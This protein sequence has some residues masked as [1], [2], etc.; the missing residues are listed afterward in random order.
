MYNI[1]LQN[2]KQTEIFYKIYALYNQEQGGR[3]RRF[4]GN[5]R[6]MARIW[7]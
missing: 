2:S 7:R 3:G 4:E 6:K 1:L 5:M